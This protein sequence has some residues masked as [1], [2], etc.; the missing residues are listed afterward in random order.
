MRRPRDLS[1]AGA[2]RYRL[3]SMQTTTGEDFSFTEP[4]LAFQIPFLDT[5]GLSYDVTSDGQRMYTIVQA[6]ED[7]V[8]RIH[9]VTGI[10]P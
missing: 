6:E 9:V 2:G 1:I 5:P 3:P 7:I 8:D 4:E 10:D